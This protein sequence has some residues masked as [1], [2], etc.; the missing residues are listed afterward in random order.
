MHELSSYELGVLAIG[1]ICFGLVLLIRGGDWTVDAAVHIANEFGLSKMFI[2]ATIVAF[3]TSVP[4]LFTSVNANIQGF[5]G[6]ALGNVVGSNIANIMLVI[7][8]AAVTY[9]I[10][11]RRAEIRRD[12]IVMLVATAIL[13]AGMIAGI[14]PFWAG[15]LMFA[16]LV[17][18]IFRSFCKDE[19]ASEFDQEV[20]E[21]EG[22]IASMRKA[23]LVLLGGIVAL[24]VGAEMLVQ[25]AVAAGVAI[26][27]PESVI[28]LTVVA[29]GTS[30]PELATCMIAAAKRHT[31]MIIGNVIGSNTF[32]I[33]SIIG[34]TALIK[35]LEV[36]DELRGFDM[37]FL[38]FITL[39]FSAW[40]WMGERVGR[41]TGIGLLIGYATFTAF[42]YRNLVFG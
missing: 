7:G 39:A 31:G 20:S 42:Q 14:F 27:V 30:L 28:G 35:P 26:G 4:E 2:G 34:L 1:C 41:K 38:V 37:W 23:L 10:L 18:F 16:L 11:I 32:N 6:I 3:G 40:L 9:P 22:R 5:P 19:G 17:A 36:V 21:H 13:V 33:L 15:A 25:G 24:A 8:A 12:L 29:F